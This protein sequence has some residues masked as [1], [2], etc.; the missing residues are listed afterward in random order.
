MKK[1]LYSI[2][3]MCGLMVMH[4]SMGY[5]Y[6]FYFNNKTERDIFLPCIYMNGCPNR[7]EESIKKGE[8]YHFGTVC[9]IIDSVSFGYGAANN[10]IWVT[11]IQSMY[12]VPVPD[13]YTFDIVDCGDDT[14]QVVPQG[15][16]CAKK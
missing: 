15:M 5:G 9:P 6:T 3:L 14:F 12:G 10:A 16:T 4:S 7:H 1:Q 11:N 13:N 2:A 8:S